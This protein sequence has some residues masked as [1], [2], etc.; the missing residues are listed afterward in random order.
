MLSNMYP[1][2]SWVLLPSLTDAIS[3]E[4]SAPKKSKLSALLSGEEWMAV[5]TVNGNLRTL[6][7]TIGH[8]IR[9][10]IR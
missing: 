10:W 2:K 4:T 5:Q 9:C 1:E 3:M 6:I 8:I 7:Q